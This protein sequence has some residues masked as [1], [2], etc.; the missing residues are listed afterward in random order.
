MKG[1]ATK[2]APVGEMLVRREK[3]V[4]ISIA[5]EKVVANPPKFEVSKGQDEEVVWVCVAEHDHR[6]NDEPCFT[7]DFETNGS[8]FYETQFSSD[9][10]VSGLVRRNVLPGPKVYKYTVRFGNLTEDPGGGVKP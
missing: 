3:R 5:A 8:P 10:P 9:S 1:T 7:I 6:P 2:K 4:E